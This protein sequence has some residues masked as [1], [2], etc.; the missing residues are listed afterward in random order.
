MASPSKDLCTLCKED[1]VTTDA[2]TWCTECDVFLCVE[3]EKHHRRSRTSKDHKTISAENYHGL[4]SFIKATS[5][6]CKI[7]GKKFEL[8]CSFHAC[9]CCVH[10]TTDKHQSCQTMKP[11]PEILKQVKSSAAVCLLEKDVKDLNE[12]FDDI[13][14]Y[15]RKRIS[16]NANRKTEA[17]QSIRSMRKSID[18]HLNKLEQQLLKDLE[19]KHSKLKSKLETLLHQVDK[20]AKQIRKLQ[21]EF[22]NMTKYATDLQ[23]YVG[24]KEIEKVT[25][26]EGNYIEDLKRGTDLNE[27]NLHLTTSPDL[28]SIL[29]DVK[30][31]G[32]IT[33]DTRPY[34]GLAN[35]RRNNQAQQLVPIPTI[36]QIKPSFSNTLKVPEG[37]GKRFFDCC[38]L[39][40]GN[41]LVLDAVRKS[42]LMFRNDGTF[43]RSIVSFI[44][45]PDS[46][47]FVKDRTVAV[48]FYNACEV[49]LVDIGKSLVDRNF[50]FPTE[51]CSGV[52]S[53]GQVLV[54]AMPSNRNVTVMNLLDESKQILK[55][56]YE[57]HVS[58]VKGNI[59]GVNFL[60]NTI[61]CYKLSGEMLWTFK[62]I[63]I[64]EPI[65]SALDKNGFIYVA[66]RKSNKIVVVSHDGKSCR[67]ILNQDNGIK[68]PQSIDI[69]VK[70]GIM[71]VISLAEDVDSVL[72]K[73]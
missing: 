28:D 30:S 46:V 5:N 68:T 72:F 35:E 51:Q 54:I 1:N 60:N 55:G 52:S 31:F 71:L 15:L 7:H 29:L 70:S 17:I 27:R 14:E 56:I 59:I 69:D 63:D 8:Y 58:L 6:L 47:C 64:V 57:H 19:T 41:C 73:L 16:T 21:N 50:N 42:L 48:S 53:D 22:S 23:T 37:Q 38:I 11:L 34:N 9:A 25:S 62:H 10:C 32:E 13:M 43:I 4:P 2:V 40:D 44:E 24:L 66:C 3:C 36:D 18:D 39:S 65:G 20:R 45:L 61:S 26:Q 33:V 12:N 49:A 67:T